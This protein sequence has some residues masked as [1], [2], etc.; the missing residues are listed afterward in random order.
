ME[1]LSS[2][3]D[4]SQAGSQLRRLSTNRSITKYGIAA[5]RFGPFRQ[6]LRPLIIKAGSSIAL[7]VN[8]MVAKLSFLR[9]V[10][11]MVVS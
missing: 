1:W 11:A 5:S 6:L 4:I 9:I 8:E 3:L 10:V 7:N 2:W